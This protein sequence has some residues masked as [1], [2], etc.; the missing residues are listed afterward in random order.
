[1]EKDS[2]TRD[3]KAVATVVMAYVAAC[4]AAILSGYLVRH[5]HPLAIAAIGDVVATM[6]IFA[7]SYVYKNSSFYDPYWSLAPIA[8]MAYWASLPEAQE[9]DRTRQ[10]AVAVLV[11]AWGL[12]LTY[13][14]F[15][16]WKGLNHEDWRYVDLQKQH[17]SA[18]WLVSFSGV[19]MFP[20]ILVFLGC[21][22]IYF[23]LTSDLRV[24]GTLD[25]VAIIITGGAVLIEG[26]ADQ[27]LR[28]FVLSPPVPGRLLTTGLWKFSRHPNYFGELGLWWGVFVFGLA[29]SPS[30]EWPIIGPVSMT[31]LFV[32]ISIPMIE[33]RHLE[34]KP[35]YHA[36]MQRTSFL[37][38]WF[39]KKDKAE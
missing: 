14:W 10:I 6:V 15:R 1:M 24:F 28:R 38:P 7:F 29:A 26:T 19:H 23:A 8:L 17:G 37:I 3:F 32:L 9:A 25:I 33:K 13:N 16:G 30:T 12:R 21:I 22:P 35:M 31:F 2:S 39:P 36:Y 34:R 5:L 18:Y 4:A 11:A 27:Q 20:T